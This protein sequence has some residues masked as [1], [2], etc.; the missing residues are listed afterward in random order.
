M[1]TVQG[2]RRK[3]AGDDT[4]KVT[5]LAVKPLPD[6]DAVESRLEEAKKQLIA[7]VQGVLDDL[8]G[9]EIETYD[10]KWKLATRLNKLCDDNGLEL[11]VEHRVEPIRLRLG[12]AKEE[13]R[14]SYFQLVTTGRTNRSFGNTRTFPRLVVRARSSKTIQ[15]G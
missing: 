14:P 15:H 12:G 2:K 13:G 5:H 3:T 11:A 9:V 8:V 10:E 4:D 7:I 6:L 1:Q